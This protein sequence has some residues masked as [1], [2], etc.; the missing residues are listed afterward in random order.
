[1]TQPNNSIDAA[2]FA[3]S[4]HEAASENAAAFEVAMQ[5][6]RAD[7]PAIEEE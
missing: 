6:E 1:M 4:L 3:A 7:N 2:T 5:E